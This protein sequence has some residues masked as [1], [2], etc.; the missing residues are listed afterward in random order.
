MRLLRPTRRTTAITAAAAGLALL[1]VGLAAP[2]ST[3][4]ELAPRGW[5]GLPTTMTL[6]T[7]QVYVGVPVT[8]TAT[9]SN[10]IVDGTVTFWVND[11]VYGLAPSVPV[12]NGKATLTWLPGYTWVKNWQVYGASFMPNP[13]QGTTSAAASTPPMSVLPN[14]GADPVTFG[15][16]GL[17]LTAGTSRP[18]TATTASGS[19]VALSASGPCTLSNIGTNGATVT[20]AGAGACAI[21]AAS[22]GGNGYLSSTASTTITVE[23]PKAPPAKKKASKKKK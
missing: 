13:Q 5:Y 10:T 14:L 12:V 22:N 11:P 6:T 15:P 1:G 21:T 17:T 20:A 19:A 7:P 8:F 3:A 23:S 4:V 2:A 18:F 9:L 16:T